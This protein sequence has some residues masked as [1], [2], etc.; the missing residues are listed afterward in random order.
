MRCCYEKNNEELKTK[1]LNLQLSEHGKNTQLKTT[2][3]QINQLKQQN[4]ILGSENI[5]AK[6]IVMKLEEKQKLKN[7]SNTVKNNNRKVK[8]A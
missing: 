2:L 4:K 8:N 6:S 5:K 1:L 7:T 3:E